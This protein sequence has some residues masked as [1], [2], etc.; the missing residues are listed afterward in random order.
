MTVLLSTIVL[1]ILGGSAGL[2]VLSLTSSRPTNLGARNGRLAACP[3]TPNCVCTQSEDRSHWIAPLNFTGPAD[4]VIP[5][6]RTII[7]S[8]SGATVLTESNVYLRT[9]F[10]SSLFRFV[11]DVEFL[12]EPESGR[13]HFRSASRVGYSDMGVNR[14]RMNLIRQRF[15][16]L[17]RKEVR[18]ASSQPKHASWHHQ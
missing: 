14:D 7:Q 11:D 4:D 6:L 10:R 9:E 13:V 1:L 8:M 12:V 18:Q 15:T 16:E 2:F 17:N 5:R 3:G